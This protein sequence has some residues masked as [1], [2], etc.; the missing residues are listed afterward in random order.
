[1]NTS[2]AS[3]KKPTVSGYHANEH[4]DGG[5]GVEKKKGQ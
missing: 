1:V 4:D 2:S 5:G 3:N